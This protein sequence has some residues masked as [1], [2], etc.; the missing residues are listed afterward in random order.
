[1]GVPALIELDRLPP[2]Q[3]SL[4]TLFLLTMFREYLKSAPESNQIPRYVIVLEEAHRIAG[5]Q[6]KAL[7]LSSDVADPVGH[8]TEIICQ[9]LVELRGLDVGIIIIDQFPSAWLQ[10]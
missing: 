6:H 9:G 1:M 7:A 2:E 4:L 5:A 10:R 8:A 3:A